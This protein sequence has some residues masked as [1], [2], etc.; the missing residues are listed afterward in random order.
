V[1]CL[2]AEELEQPGEG[3]SVMTRATNARVVLV[4]CGKSTEAWEIA[5]KVVQRK[6]AACVNVFPEPMQSVYRWKGK[7][8]VAS[9]YLLVIKTTEKRLED[10]QEEVLGLHS[11]ETPEFLVLPVEGGSIGYLEWLGASVI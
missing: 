11:Y 7:V 1:T 5:R 9:E 2:E 8:K 3:D 6:L 4:T 10:L